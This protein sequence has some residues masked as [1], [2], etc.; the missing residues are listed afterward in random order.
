MMTITAQVPASAFQKDFTIT[1]LNVGK[2]TGATRFAVPWPAFLRP[3]EQGG[4]DAFRLAK[5]RAN[6]IGG[7]LAVVDGEESYVFYRE[8]AFALRIDVINS[9]KK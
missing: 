3:D 6:S 7:R 2:T 8:S 1:R 9:R 5:R 4:R